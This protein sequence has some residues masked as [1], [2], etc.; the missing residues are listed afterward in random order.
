MTQFLFTRIT[1]EVH[2]H[3]YIFHFLRSLGPFFVVLFAALRLLYSVRIIHRTVNHLP[4]LIIDIQFVDV[5]HGRIEM[6][7]F[8]AFK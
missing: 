3:S 6:S 7:I 1:N 5:G 2:S 8:Y 4:E